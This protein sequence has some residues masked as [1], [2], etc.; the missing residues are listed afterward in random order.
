MKKKLLYGFL[1]ILT[2]LLVFSPETSIFYAKE[3]L[4]LCEN[5]I[6][7]SLFPFFVCSGLLIYSGFSENLANFSKPVMRPLFNVNPAGASAFILGILSGYPLGALTACQ[8]YEKSYISK[9]EAERLLSFC[10]NSGPL[11]I[12]GAVGVSLYHSPKAGLILYICHILSAFL[13]G[14]LFKYYKKDDYMPPVLIPKTESATF[15]KIFKTVLTNS[16]ESMLTVCGAVLF[17]ATI[18]GVL[19]NLFPISDILRNI[20]SGLAEFSSGI[21]NISKSSLSIIEKLTISSFIVGFAGF[22]VHVQ[23]ASIVSSYGLSLFP[24]ILGKTIQGFLSAILVF[25]TLKFLPCEVSVFSPLEV[26]ISGAF[27]IASLFT[28]IAVLS[29]LFTMLLS[30]IY[31]LF[32]K[33]QNKNEA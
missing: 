16:I 7:P 12:M 15:P 13:T 24:Y 20:L 9:T 28:I 25:L 29:V 21:S 19:I 18:S 3:A 33:K 27:F 1:L 31:L 8:L 2:L 10:N 5:V 11:F 14:M 30:I 23:V 26:E 6:I 17:F 22:S 4:S 32:K